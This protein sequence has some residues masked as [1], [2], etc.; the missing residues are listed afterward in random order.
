MKSF[1]AIGF[2]TIVISALLAPVVFKCEP[3]EDGLRPVRPGDVVVNKFGTRGVITMET[4][5]HYGVW[6]VRLKDGEIQYWT[7]AEIA[8]REE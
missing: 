7:S 5:H 4:P 3:R 8:Y 2:V 1:A 6:N